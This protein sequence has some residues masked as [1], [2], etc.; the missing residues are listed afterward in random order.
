MIHGATHIN[1]KLKRILRLLA[2]A[3]FIGLACILP[4]PLSITRKDDTPKYFIEQIDQN[5]EDGNEDDIKDIF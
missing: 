4:I 5:E 1:M 2:L 3:L